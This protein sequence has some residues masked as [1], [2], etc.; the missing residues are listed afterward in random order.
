MRLFCHSDKASGKQASKR[1]GGLFKGR[2]QRTAANQAEPVGHGAM[3]DRQQ[4]AVE[5]VPHLQLAALSQSAMMGGGAAEPA[6][7][8]ASRVTVGCSE[9]AAEV[10]EAAPCA[11]AVQA[12]AERTG[13]LAAAAQSAK[14]H[15]SSCLTL[16]G[17]AADIVNVLREGE[18]LLPAGSVECLFQ[19]ESLIGNA[20]TLAAS[21]GTDSWLLAACAVDGGAGDAL[22]LLGTKLVAALKDEGMAC[23]PGLARLPAP[24]VH[25]GARAL[26]RRL[27]QLGSG[28]LAAGLALLA[29]NEDER[30]KLAESLGVDPQDIARGA[31][32]ILEAG[33]LEE[34]DLGATAADDALAEHRPGLGLVF[35]M[36][37]AFGL[38]GEA[39]RAAPEL[40]SFRCTKLAREAGLLDGSLTTQALDVLFAAAKG[41]GARTLSF[42][43]FL[44]LLRAMADKKGVPVGQVAAAVAAMRAP[45]LRGTTPEAVKFHDDRSLYTGVYRGGMSVVDHRPDLG[46]L[47]D[48]DAAEK[49]QRRA[50]SGSSAPRRTS[51][52]TAASLAAL[53]LTP[54]AVGNDEAATPGHFAAGMLKTPGSGASVSSAP[55]PRG[56]APTPRGMPLLSPRWA[57]EAPPAAADETEARN[58]RRVFDQFAAFGRS[59]GAAG[60]LTLDSAQYAKLCREAKLLGRGLTATRADLTFTAAVGAKGARRMSFQ[61]FVGSLPRL[62]EAR[63]CERG[64]VVRRLLACEGPTLSRAT[65]PDAV[66]LFD[67]K[68]N[69]SGV[70]GR[71][72]PSTLDKG[73]VTLEG[74]CDRSGRSAS[75]LAPVL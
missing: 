20:A 17:F 47:V 63:G 72:G 68:S 2:K 8:A 74:L 15:R 33:L 14:A 59:Q 39:A 27:R 56:T 52:G 49:A 43:A 4:L 3:Q 73:R 54:S 26:R 44:R 66:P 18:P 22:Q 60:E 35:S 25:N 65:T 53:S 23:L 48:R 69:F 55:T 5:D 51:T 7:S 46:K 11:E 62:A 58:L 29:G 70:A 41:R 42:D 34:E 19:L 40:D 12:V 16:A 75:L 38:H 61:A 24:D 64:E 67:D 6:A 9:A 36:Y 13:E 30:C 1:G 31:A 50:S 71:G 28:S 10:P 45:E 37:A 57:A 32:H 21:C